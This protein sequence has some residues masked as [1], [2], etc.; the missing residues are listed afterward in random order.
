[1]RHRACPI[2]D[3]CAAYYLQIFLLIRA[4][5]TP[6]AHI[7]KPEETNSYRQLSQMLLLRVW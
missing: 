4:R 1:M 6:I 5:Y 7:Q 2:K 3:V